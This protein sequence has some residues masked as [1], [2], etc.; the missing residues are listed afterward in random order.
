[1]DV[2]P[3]SPVYKLQDPGHRTSPLQTNVLTGKKKL[4][5]TNHLPIGWVGE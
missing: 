1:M 4:E 3:D 2:N 5:P